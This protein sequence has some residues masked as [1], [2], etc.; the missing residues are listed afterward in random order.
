MKTD[1]QKQAGEAA[2]IHGTKAPLVI[3][4]AWQ[5]ACDA[6]A[7]CDLRDPSEIRPS[8]PIIRVYGAT[9]EDATV[10]AREVLRACNSHAALLCALESMITHTDQLLNKRYPFA[11]TFEDLQ[12]ARQVVANV[13]QLP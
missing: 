12:T 11:E 2:H 3:G 13:K 5:G 9:V 4:E 10:R 8:D 1:T 7:K 6:S